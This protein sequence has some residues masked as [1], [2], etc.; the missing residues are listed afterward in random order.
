MNVSGRD[1]ENM[2]NLM[3]LKLE[4][5]EKV[6]CLKNKFNLLIYLKTNYLP[7]YQICLGTIVLEYEQHTS[8][9]LLYKKQP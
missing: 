7:I 5:K 8:T 1:H 9:L 6:E 3:T 2:K 4:I